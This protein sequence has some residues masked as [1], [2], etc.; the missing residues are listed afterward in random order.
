MRTTKDYIQKNNTALFDWLVFAISF[1]L[2][3]I[4]PGL[5]AFAS[6]PSFSFWMLAALLLY[7]SGAWL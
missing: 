5:K 7:I 2:G 3:F 1:S 4:F 6:S